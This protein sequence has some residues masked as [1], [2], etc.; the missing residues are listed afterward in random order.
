MPETLRQALNLPFDEQIE[1]FRAKLNLPTERWDD[2]KKG[3]HDRAFVVA[4][5]MKADLLDDLRQAVSPLQRTTLEQ[6]RKD[7]RAIVQKRGWHG[8]TGEG[9]PAGE[10]WRTRVIFE[11]N[12]RTSL[13]A[14]RWRQ[15][16]DPRTLKAMPYWRYVHSDSVLH[17]RPHHLAWHGLTLRHDHP[18]WKTHFAPNG[19][20]C[21]CKIVAVRAPRAGDATEPPAGWDARDAKGSLPGIDRGWDYAPGAN[22]ATPLRELVEQKLIKLDA[23]IGA[24][25]WETLRPAVLAE[26]E[27]A[28]N[29]WL[30]GVEAGAE[31][32]TLG[33]LGAIDPVD[34]GLLRRVGIEPTTAEVYVRPGVIKG[35][36]ANRHSEK[37][38]ALNPAQWA[39]LPERFDGAVA[40]LYDTVS[41][42]PLWLLAGG[43]RLPQLAVAIDIEVGNPKRR[44]NAVVSAYLALPDEIR[45][46]IAAKT[47]VLLRGKVE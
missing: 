7:F 2:I 3:A 33:L 10:A 6:F 16:T 27:L 13:A 46:R 9:T 15:L 8:W 24:A 20:G 44:V 19:W 5:A 32:N 42:K 40:L 25:M 29:N 36:K 14:G 31:R 37:G 45:R 38:D 43:D 39:T 11:T 28:W 47:L 4:G 1:F 41:G 23:G 17:P 18:F 35:P 30:K 12:V 21:R 26:R 34:V 22:A